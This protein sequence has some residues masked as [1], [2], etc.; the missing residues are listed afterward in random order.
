MTQALNITVLMPGPQSKY[1]KAMNIKRS[2]T[3]KKMFSTLFF[4][5][6]NL[7]NAAKLKY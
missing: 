4:R 1:N 3:F 5:G 7:E 2:A 6:T